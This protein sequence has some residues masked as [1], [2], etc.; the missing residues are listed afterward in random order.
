MKISPLVKYL[1]QLNKFTVRPAN[2]VVHDQLAPIL[3]SVESSNIQYPE[4]LEQLAGGYQ[5]IIGDITAFNQ[6]IDQIKSKIKS[7]ISELEPA[8]FSNSYQQYDENLRPNE[9]DDIVLHRRF[10]I[11][12]EISQLVESRIKQGSDWKHSG[13]IIRPGLEDWMGHMVSLNPLYLLDES[14]DLLQ[15]VKNSF[16]SEYVARLRFIKIDKNLKENFLSLVP[17]NQISFCLVYNF[18]NYKPMEVITQYLKEIYTK[19]KPG[20]VVALTINNCDR[21]SAVELVEQNTASYTPGHMICKLAE[22]ILFEVR[23]QTDLNNSVT[24]I[25]LSKPGKL[26]SIRGGQALAKILAR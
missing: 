18:F 24:W 16:N 17:E 8:Y 10:H 9:I 3:H 19:L 4:L 7:Q 23:Y 1:E 21:H 2:A 25:E 15:P 26:S 13:M 20:G 11:T 5:T 22:S 12:K 6:T 14:Y